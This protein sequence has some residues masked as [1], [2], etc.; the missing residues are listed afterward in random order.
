[1][2]DYLKEAFLF[3]WNLLFFL[4][5]TAA[6]AV[7]LVKKLGGELTGLAFLIELTFLNGKSKLNG[8]HVFSV[9]QY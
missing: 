9:I 5:G 2:P 6:A 3:R 7:Q 4:G 1:M 8:E